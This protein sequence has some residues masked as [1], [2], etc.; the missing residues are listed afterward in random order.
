MPPSPWL[1]PE[2]SPTPDRTASFIEYL[3]WMRSPNVADKDSTKLE[4]LQN[5]QNNA[6]YHQRLTLLCDR[7]RSF[8]GQQGT[9]L[10]LTCPWRIRVGG[11]TG[12]ENILLP[13]FDALGMPYL[14]SSSLRGVARSKAIREVG[15]ENIAP[16]FG[17]LNATNPAHRAGKVIFFDAYP[18]PDTQSQGAIRNRN[19]NQ[20]GGLA[21]DMAN[22]IWSWQESQLQYSPNPNLFF[23]LKQAKFVI[24]LRPMA[25]CDEATFQ[26]VVEWLRNGLTESGLGS[27][28]NTGYG[29]LVLS[30]SPNTPSTNNLPGE[31]F[32]VEFELEG[33]FIHGIQE[34]TQW[35]WEEREGQWVHRGKP[36]AEIRPVAFKSML[37]YWFR[38]LA[39]GVLP[40]DSV[41]NWE[42]NIFGGINPQR[43]GWLRCHV[44]P[45]KNNEPNLQT[46]ILVLANPPEIPENKKNE[47]KKLCKNLT[48]IMFHLGGIGQGARRPCYQ[49]NNPPFWR[50]SSLTCILDDNCSQEEEEFWE[51]PENIGEFRKLFRRRLQSFYRSLAQ[52]SQVEINSQ[53][54]LSVN[55]EADWTEAIDANCR[56]VICQG[57]KRNNKVCALAVLHSQELKK[58]GDYDP[59]LCGGV[60]P[61]T[62][63]PVWITHLEEV[64]F[65]VVTVF[66]VNNPPQQNFLQHLRNQAAQYVT[67]WK[68]PQPR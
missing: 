5:A 38:A 17:D 14:P 58:N 31:F 23:S 36:Q 67:V 34:F 46:G 15:E 62:P 6:N 9:I 8:A 21:L 60:N 4:I 19:Q 45:G 16:Y 40:T 49:R 55:T 20:N 50:G 48:W 13:A 47:V 68:F 32:R 53:Q 29:R 65:Q 35:E 64:D 11:H 56:I 61:P 26:Q 41:K 3:R 28:L 10:E 42:A 59:D 1:N 24:G 2:D 39:R 44:L 54:P 25:G 52:L 37:R 30:S 12:P 63:S 33:Q 27:Q 57:Q 22:N 51:I 43:L 7:V 66:G 18:L